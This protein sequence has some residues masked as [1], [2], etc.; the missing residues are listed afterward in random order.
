MFLINNH[1]TN[2]GNSLSKSKSK[3]LLESKNINVL[4][5]NFEGKFFKDVTKSSGLLNDAFSLSASIIDI[6]NDF[7]KVPP[8]F[9][10]KDS[11]TFILNSL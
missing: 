10:A 2:R 1:F 5:K 11:L 6:N 4:F 7:C 9:K 8:C 3:D